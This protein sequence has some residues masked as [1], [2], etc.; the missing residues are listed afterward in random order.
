MKDKREK[1]G[2]KQKG[3]TKHGEPTVNLA[4]RIPES[5]YNAFELIPGSKTEKLIE[6]VKYFVEK[7]K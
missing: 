7:A 5:L 2:G 4:G 3:F 1:T 6:A